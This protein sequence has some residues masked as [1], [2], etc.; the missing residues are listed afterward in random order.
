MF[1]SINANTVSTSSSTTETSGGSTSTKISKS[2]S[3]TTT[4]QQTT[5]TSVSSSGGNSGVST[6]TSTSITSS[7]SITTSSSSSGPA[8]YVLD[9]KA[10]LDNGTTL[11]GLRVVISAGNTMVNSS[12]L[13]ASFDLKGGTTYNITVSDGNGYYF[14]RWKT[15]Q[16]SRSIIVVLSGDLILTADYRAAGLQT[17]SVYGKDVENRTVA[18]P[19]V[20][21]YKNGIMNGSDVLP[22]NFT[23][24]Y[25]ERVSVVAF[26]ATSLSFKDWNDNL[27]MTNE[28]YNFTVKDN[29]S[30]TAY[31]IPGAVPFT[32]P[33]PGNYTIT[34]I[35][36][37]LDGGELIGAYFQ[38]RINGVWNNYV[39][40]WTPASVQIPANV[41]EMLVMYHCARVDPC[42]QRF[43]VY[44]HYNDSA[45]TLTRWIYIPPGSGNVVI[46]SF[47]EI[48][49]ASGVV[50]VH[51]NGVDSIYH[52]N[53]YNCTC[54][55]LITIY[56]NNTPMA[57]SLTPYSFFLWKG[58]NYTVN[59]GPI[60]GYTF[61]DWDNGV[62]ST[63][64]SLVPT[65]EYVDAYD[66]YAYDQDIA[67]IYQKDRS[68]GGIG[69]PTTLASVMIGYSASLTSATVLMFCFLA[70]WGLIAPGKR[71]ATMRNRSFRF[72]PR[73]FR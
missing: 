17:I 68:S 12:Q 52:R 44:R 1:A 18:G 16:S 34:V 65:P 51:V 24:T 4:T 29:T 59:L 55:A 10:Q 35:S 48:V 58:A 47:Y 45:N 8:S 20:Y 25:G 6:T 41:T 50:Y 73:M 22:A 7:S 49:P 66:P 71:I 36:H 5:T 32:P 63:N 53:L 72:R 37:T 11:S 70:I 14:D 64:R 21:F 60:S 62:T 28:A 27:S 23:A 67:G 38:V 57:Q 43:F 42:T 46:N 56:Q 30:L 19:T 15:G 69:V 9:I 26:G 33:G 39:Q 3:A 40:G 54:G 61:V 2:I 13:P 31:Y